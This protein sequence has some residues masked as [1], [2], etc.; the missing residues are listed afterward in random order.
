M[1]HGIRISQTSGSLHG[2][3]TYP[4]L[5]TQLIAHVIESV[6]MKVAMNNI[7]NDKIHP[8]PFIS[9]HQASKCMESELEFG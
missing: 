8:E 3:S 4:Y 9:L 6:I 2:A 5:F 1:K 7:I